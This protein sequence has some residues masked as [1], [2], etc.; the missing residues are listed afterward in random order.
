MEEKG[1]PDGVIF[2]R[3]DGSK[4]AAKCVGGSAAQ[5]SLFPFIDAALGVRHQPLGKDEAETVF[6][7]RPSHSSIQ[8]CSTDQ[9]QEMRSYMPIEHRELLEEVEKL[10][11]LRVYIE[12]REDNRKLVEA[13]NSCLQKLANWRS[14]HIG[15]VTTHI[16]SPSRNSHSA[17]QRPDPE[18]VKDGLS[19]RD[20][21]KLQGTGG[22]ALIPFLKSAK[23][24]TMETCLR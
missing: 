20:E 5:S 3:A 17:Y 7:V 4:V 11:S 14:R 8:R 1:M 16:V 6:Q 15:V 21:G 2:H 19:I 23:E 10:P 12:S 24:D 13:Y 9:G 18:E 22:S